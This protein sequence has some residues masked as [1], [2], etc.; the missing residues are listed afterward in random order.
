MHDD[1]ES[2]MRMRSYDRMK[3]RVTIR[4]RDYRSNDRLAYQVP[5][6][7]NIIVVG[8]IA[9]F[10]LWNSYHMCR[11]AINSQ[12]RAPIL[13]ALFLSLSVN[14]I[15]LRSLVAKR[16]PRSK[17]KDGGA[18]AEKYGCPR[19]SR[20]FP[21]G[22][23]AIWLPHRIVKLVGACKI[24]GTLLRLTFIELSAPFHR[25]IGNI[26]DTEIKKSKAFGDFWFIDV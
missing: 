16:R 23:V 26:D 24:W 13:S 15:T 11:R 10:S 18:D 7:N 6:G 8:R 12:L 3:A 4:Y 9:V 17:R 2:A 25:Q 21:L 1:E 20:W 5:R 14:L 22:R 19:I